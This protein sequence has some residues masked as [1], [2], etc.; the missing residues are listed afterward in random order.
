M[1]ITIEG[2]QMRW[3]EEK[4]ETRGFSVE[5]GR[6]DGGKGD[7]GNGK[8]IKKKVDGQKKRKNGKKAQRGTRETRYERE[9]RSKNIILERSGIKKKRG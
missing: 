6:W 1:K 8:R 5:A 3:N 7:N 9:E 2:V 4:E